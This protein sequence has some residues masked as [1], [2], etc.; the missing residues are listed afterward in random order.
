MVRS[1][2]ALIQADARHRQVVTLSEGPDPQ[3]W[4]VD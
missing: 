2:H 4:F 1:L 3:R